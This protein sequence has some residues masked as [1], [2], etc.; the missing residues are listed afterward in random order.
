MNLKLKPAQKPRVDNKKYF[1]KRSHYGDVSESKAEN[2]WF[3]HVLFSY[4]SA[5]LFD[6]TWKE[7]RDVELQHGFR[8][9]VFNQRRQCSQPSSSRL[10]C[11]FTP[12]DSLKRANL[13]LSTCIIQIQLCDLSIF[14]L[15]AGSDFGILLVYGGCSCWMA[16][17]GPRVQKK[18]HI[19]MMGRSLH[20]LIWAPGEPMSLCT[21]AVNCNGCTA[22]LQKNK[23]QTS[24]VIN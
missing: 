24:S 13:P 22:L 15:R 21:R 12:H 19:W 14:N 6:L 3:S 2:H 9:I 16:F 10:L 17:L 11:H 20:W 5:W 7:E 8:R 18:L 23:Y 1:K 4:I